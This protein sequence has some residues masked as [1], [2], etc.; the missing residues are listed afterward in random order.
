M[1]SFVQKSRCSV[2]DVI[3]GHVLMLRYVILLEVIASGVVALSTSEATYLQYLTG[4]SH[5]A[6]ALDYTVKISV[7]R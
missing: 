5:T 3:S 1:H 2:D 4:T 7:Y 6:F